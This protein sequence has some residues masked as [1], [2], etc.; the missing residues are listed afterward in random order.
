M[1]LLTEIPFEDITQTPPLVRDYLS[2]HLPGYEDQKFNPENV[3][4]A[5]NRRVGQFTAEKRRILVETLTRQMVNAAPAQKDNLRLL[6]K[7]NS[8]TV[9]TGHQLNLFSGPV[10][11]FYKI[12]QTLTTAQQLSRQHPDFHFLP[13]FWMATEDHDLAEIETFQTRDGRYSLREKSGPPVGRILLNDLTFIEDFSRDIQGLPFADELVSVMRE[14]YQSGHTLAQA[15]RMLVQH[16]FGEKGLLV[17]DGDDAALKKQMV[18]T[19]QGELQFSE[20]QNHTKETVRLLLEEY[21]K[22]Q[23]NPR[24]VNLFYL[25]E[26]RHRIDRGQNFYLQSSAKTFSREEIIAE[27][28]N[29]PEK[30]SPNALLRPVFQET[31]LPNILY[32]GGNA[33]IA[34]WLELKGYFKFLGLPYPMLL[35][36]QSVI[37]LTPKQIGKAEKLGLTPREIVLEPKETLDAQLLEGSSLLPKLTELEKQLQQSYAQLKNQAT[38]TDITFENLVNAETHRMEKSFRRMAARLVKAQRRK[39]ADKVER[40]WALAAEINPKGIWQERI[41]NF[42]VFYAEY[43][44]DWLEACYSLL[45]APAPPGLLLAEI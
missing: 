27:V 14:A 36:R 18:E 24:E 42:S 43:G 13:V 38:E 28:E 29:R 15:T 5:A 31:I 41:W 1:R 20:L 30:F 21:G 8:V 40:T 19:F 4:K 25:D 22:V 37:W 6:A 26:N 33:E 2:G 7:E 34:Y 3:T 35:P 9:T 45:E 11:F 32:I 12:I 10:F 17:I 16:F 23:V 39:Q 44:P